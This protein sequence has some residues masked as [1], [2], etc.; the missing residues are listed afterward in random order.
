MFWRHIELKVIILSEI[1]RLEEKSDF[2]SLRK[3]TTKQDRG[4]EKL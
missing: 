4:S 3:E 1:G 2:L